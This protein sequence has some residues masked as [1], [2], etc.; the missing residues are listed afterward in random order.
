MSCTKQVCFAKSHAIRDF[1]D[2][3]PFFN[4]RFS[5]YKSLIILRFASYRK[6][7][8]T[9]PLPLVLPIQPLPSI[10]AQT[11]YA[12]SIFCCFPNKFDENHTFHGYFWVTARKNGAKMETENK[13]GHLKLSNKPRNG[14]NRNEKR[15]VDHFPSLHKATCSDSQCRGI[16]LS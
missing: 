6:R 3:Y 7:V 13:Q 10:F 9:D 1:K 5:L 11:R 2:P 15:L 12:V 4:C 14:C 8:L 16:R